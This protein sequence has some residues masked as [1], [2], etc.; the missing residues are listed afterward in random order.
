[1]YASVATHVTVVAPGVVVPT[2]PASALPPAAV[3]G[4]GTGPGVEFGDGVR[5]FVVAV[6]GGVVSASESGSVS[7]SSTRGPTSTATATATGVPMRP[8]ATEAPAPTGDGGQKTWMDGK[9][10]GVGNRVL[11]GVGVGVG[12]P[13]LAGV[14]GGIM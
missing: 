3:T 4:A 10:G 8:T 6:E 1:M 5:G 9:T 12:V 2:F 14:V 11:V 13:V 7:S